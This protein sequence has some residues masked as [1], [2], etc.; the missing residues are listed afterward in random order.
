MEVMLRSRKMRMKIWSLDPA[1][2]KS[3]K[4]E[5]PAEADVDTW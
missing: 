3:K 4:A 2:R 1:T 5:K